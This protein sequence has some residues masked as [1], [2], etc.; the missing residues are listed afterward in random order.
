MFYFKVKLVNGDEFTFHKRCN[1]INYDNENLC[2]FQE[3]YA[4]EYYT[5]A[6]IPYKSIEY[7]V[8]EEM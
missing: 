8:R 2:V 6:I 5:L 1:W 3:H 4:T 7:I